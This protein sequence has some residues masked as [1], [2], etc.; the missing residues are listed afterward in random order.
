[1]PLKQLFRPCLVAAALA[2][3]GVMLHSEGARAEHRTFW[4]SV[5][6]Q[7]F[8]HTM[9][10]PGFAPGAA[11]PIVVCNGLPNNALSVALREAIGNW[12]SSGGAGFSAFWLFGPNEIFGPCPSLAQI[13]IDVELSCCPSP[14]YYFPT[15]VDLLGFTTKARLEWELGWDGTASGLRAVFTHELG[16]ALGLDEQ[17]SH[18]GGCSSGPSSV[19]DTGDID[20]AASFVKGPCDSDTPTAN[21]RV[22]VAEVFSLN[23]GSPPAPQL[24]WGLPSDS[25]GFIAVFKAANGSSYSYQRLVCGGLAAGITAVF[26]YPSNPHI[27]WATLPYSSDGR[28]V[29]YQL[30]TSSGMPSIA[31]HAGKRTTFGRVFGS[32]RTNLYGNRTERAV[33]HN[34]STVSVYAEARNGDEVAAT[35]WCKETIGPNA[36]LGCSL[37]AGNLPTVFLYQ[38]QFRHRLALGTGDTDFD[39]CS[40]A[41]ELGTDPLFGGDRDLHSTWD[42]YD[43]PDLL[44]SGAGTGARN[45]SIGL[46][47]TLDIL[48]WFGYS[49][50]T[51][52]Y[53][54]DRN[55]NGIRDGEEFDRTAGPVGAEYRTVPSS[56]GIGLTD[57]LL[58][59]QSFGHSCTA[60]P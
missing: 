24:I 40:D 56:D 11:R 45:G 52:E 57:A 22:R 50:S 31:F 41:E 8:N 34:M 47:D 26:P 9:E 42:F 28:G 20:F 59:Q 37:D 7:H 25:N 51:L 49:P 60:P 1:M 2:I 36:A 4:T 55:G 54:I 29:C 32:L 43:V 39:G 16:H 13:Q 15:A 30:R 48:S 23:T 58:N 3:A 14:A 6:Q 18:I 46:A 12:N 19:M 5:F 17:Y 53:Q 33:M 35:P 44:P 27:G 21:D 10:V 38:E